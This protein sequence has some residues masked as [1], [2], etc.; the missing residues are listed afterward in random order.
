MDRTAQLRVFEAQTANVKRL[1]GA[2][3]QV[4]RSINHAIRRRDEASEGAHTLV[5]ALLYCAWLEALFSKLIH[6]P[7]GFELGEIKEIKKTCNASGIAA[8]WIKCVELG[9]NRINASKPTNSGP[10]IRKTLERHIN[11]YVEEPAKLR[12]KIAHGQWRVALNKEHTAVNQTATNDLLAIDL[13]TVDRWTNV[14][15]ML[16]KIIESL[17]ESPK[18]TFRR[19]Y[20]LLIEQ[21]NESIKSVS[22]WTRHSRAEILGRKPGNRQ[23][24]PR[25]HK[26]PGD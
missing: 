7:Y 10:N 22:S 5:L 9:V 4:R 25:H 11:N 1:E 18:R 13:V 19:D 3:R 15:R 21:L 14:V 8:A 16:T 2:L 17:I 23:T 26:L 20:W 6:T 12:N 24:P